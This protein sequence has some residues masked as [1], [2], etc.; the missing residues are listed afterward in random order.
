MPSRGVQY[1]RRYKRE[2]DIKAMQASRP[3][4][5]KAKYGLLREMS[6][7]SNSTYLDPR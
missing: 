6:E 4:H 7:A 2:H 5:R 3:N 1:I